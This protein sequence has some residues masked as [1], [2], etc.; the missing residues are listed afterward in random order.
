MSCYLYEE[1]CDLR[2]GQRETSEM[3]DEFNCEFYA[4]P[5]TA[6]DSTFLTETSRLM[7]AN[8][9]LVYGLDNYFIEDN[10][11]DSPEDNYNEVC[12]SDEEEIQNPEWLK[13]RSTNFSNFFQNSLKEPAIKKKTKTNPDS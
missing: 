13:K 6:H 3:Y 2:K 4:D 7:C 9:D 8:D 1:I 5:V 11:N 12:Y 10:Y